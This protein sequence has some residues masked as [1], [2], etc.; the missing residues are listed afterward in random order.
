MDAPFRMR[1]EERD[2]RRFVGRERELELLERVLGDDPPAS[3]VLV[4]G[5]GGVGKSTLLREL[6]RRAG[7]AGRTAHRIDARELA[8]APRRLELLLE[9][10]ARQPRPLLLV[11]TYE[12]APALGAYLRSD[13]LPR[14]PADAR[15]VIAGRRPP[16]AAWI[17]DGW[18]AVTLTLGLGP[19]GDADARALLERQGVADPDVEAAVL[20]WARGLPLA[21]AVAADA[22]AGGALDPSALDADTDLAATLL[23]RLAG[24]EIDGADR[25]VLAVAAIA[26]AVDA[27]LL[28][29]VLPGAD[30]GRAEAWLRERSFAEPLG[31]RVTL[32]ERV[33]ASL[34][35]GL[36]AQDPQRER[37][38]RRRIADYLHA[39]AL[40]GEPALVVD[41][42]TLISDPAVR[43]GMTAETGPRYRIDGVRPGDDAVLA[44]A[45]GVGERAWW[46]GVKRFFE[47]APERIAT[48]R[49]GA[50]ALAGLCISVTPG[51]APGWASEDAI[52]GPWLADAA[53]RAPD[54]NAL[55]WRDSFDLSATAG[56]AG[57]PVI[58]LLNTAA[59]LLSG[60][61]NVRW[62]YGAAD[63]GDARAR[64]LSA[65]IGAV[66][67]PE[68]DV[69]DGERVVQCH[70]LDHGP[71]GLLDSVRAL[72]YRDLGLP[73]PAPA[74][75]GE[76]SADLVR[77]ALRAFHDPVALA[78]SPL[79]VGAT[80]A[81]RAAA[82]R[83]LL[84]T[85]A[86]GAFG[87]S[88]DERLLRATIERG[89]LDPHGG[90][91]RAALDLHVSRTT[92][93]R[94][95]ATATSRVARYL[96]AQRRG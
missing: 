92:Y 35:D 39:R 26:P 46:P 80:A 70:L 95:L 90:H 62:F 30:G 85:A 29:A 24:D 32:H 17:E 12:Q 6:A 22:A 55:L 10:A 61:P 49:D 14:L 8:G 40:V 33:R 53:R 1:V 28:A 96:L 74:D 16:E 5:P 7:T 81:E 77:D 36:V 52:L 78:A 91:E 57:S 63:P 27:D 94:R 4:H 56:E 34:R 50:G 83:G 21:L 93:F 76:E 64:A 65:A 75:R 18:E 38:L 87:D 82:V 43:W 58:G 89:Y 79:A 68:L 67:V 15:V 37:D 3:V 41:L 73:A 54:G 23:R 71:G 2:A 9:G 84:R 13:V 86:A 47:Q 44:A 69:R 42:A 25:D 51:N 60:L 45:T 19:F 20:R 72:V 66:H 11:D 48:V 88:E 31:T 59:S